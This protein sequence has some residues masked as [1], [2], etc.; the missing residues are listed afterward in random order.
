[1]GRNTGQAEGKSLQAAHQHGDRHYQQE[2]VDPIRGPQTTA[3]QLEDP[4]LLAAEHQHQFGPLTAVAPE[5][6]VPETTAV[7]TGQPQS[8][9]LT[10]HRRSGSVDPSVGPQPHKLARADLT[11]EPGLQ[12]SAGESAIGQVCDGTEPGHKLIGLLQ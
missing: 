4:G 7:A 2:P 3:L 6:H 10:A 9:H 8:A 12:L 5:L 11:S 1:M